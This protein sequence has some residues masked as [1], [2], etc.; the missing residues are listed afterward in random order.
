MKNDVWDIVPRPKGKS[1][2]TSKWIYKIKHAVD[3]SIEKHKV[4]FMARGFSQVEGI[5]YEDTFS[6]IAQYTSIRTIIALASALVWRLHQ[7]DMKTVFF[8]GE[9]EEE[10]Y[11]KQPDDFVIHG[12][13]SH[14]CRLKKALYGLKQAPRASYARIDGYLMSL[15]FSKSVID[16]NLYYKVDN[17]ESLILTLYV[18]DLFLTRAEHLITWCKHELAFELEMKDLRMMYYFLGLEVWQRTY[19][20]FPS[21]GKCTVEILRRF[22]MTY[23]KSMTT[24]MVRNLKKLSESSSN[25]NLIDP[26]MYR[27][28]I[29]SLMYLVNTRPDICYA[30]NA[31]SQFMSQSRQ[32]HWVIV[33]HVLRYLRG[34]VGYD[35]RYA[36]SID[37]RLQGYADSDWAGST[38]DKKSTFECCFSL[39]S[40]MV[41]WCSMKRTFVA[42]STIE[43]EYIVVRTTVREAVWLRKLLAGLFGQMLDPTVIHCD[44]QRCVKLS[45]NLVSHDNTK[46]VEIKY[47]SIRDIVQRK[48]V[49]VEYLPT[50]EQITDVLTKPLAR[51]KFVYF[52]DKLGMTENVPLAE[53]EC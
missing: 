13:E 9:I 6:P 38:I 28:L 24:S 30:V 44:N 29:G 31:F 39:G 1:V 33:K 36:S 46:H 25:S 18:D 34:T 20:I 5:D 7:M 11:I 3:G 45:E 10:V 4:R 51:S 47:H 12:K 32:I 22:G 26:T 43:V 21:Q 50:D 52:C 14:V 42:L 17:G 37:M 16:A 48:A 53:R 23:C 35:L 15:G 49:Q 27:Q 41:S 8:N 2:V 19:E 40:A